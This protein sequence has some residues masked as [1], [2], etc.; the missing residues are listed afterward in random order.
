MIWWAGDHLQCAYYVVTMSTFCA[1][2]LG[3]ARPNIDLESY[4]IPDVI[5]L[6]HRS[7]FCRRVIFVFYLFYCQRGCL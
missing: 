3:G 7:I 2:V 5:E 4:I 1:R 6:P